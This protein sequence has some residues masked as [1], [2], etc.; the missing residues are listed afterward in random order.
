MRAVL[1]ETP[2]QKMRSEVVAETWHCLSMEGTKERR[3]HGDA[4]TTLAMWEQPQC[5][6]VR[7]IKSRS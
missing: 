1:L 6:T 2:L 5:R 3:Q 4:N 7:G